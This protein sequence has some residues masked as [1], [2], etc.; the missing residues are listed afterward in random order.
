MARRKVNAAPSDAHSDDL[1]ELIAEFW[2]DPLGFVDF[3]YPWGEP[4]PLQF[5]TGPDD[6]Q[7]EYLIALGEAVRAR[8]AV[9]DL[10]AYLSATAT[11]HGTGKS[12][13]V[14]WIVQ[15]LMSTREDP[16]IVVT[17]N[18]LNQL[19]TKTWRE[20]SKWHRMLINADW[21]QW[22]ATK[23]YLKERPETWAAHAIPW[24]KERSEAFAGTHAK[25]VLMIFDEAS[26]V[27]DSI[28]ETAEGALTTA[29]ALW[30]VF[31]NPTKNTGR[32]RECWRRFRH[33]WDCRQVDSRKARKANQGQLNTWVEDYGED[34]DFVRVR[35][36]GEFPRAASSQ[37]IGGD[38]V[39]Q[40]QNEFKR[41]FG[42]RLQKA[43]A[44][45]PGGLALE[46]LDENTIAPRIMAVD[47]ARK[48]GDQSVIGIRQGKCFVPVAKYRDLDGPQLAYRVA[49]WIIGEQPD[50]VFI[51][52]VGYGASCLDTLRDLG[53]EVEDVNG[54]LKALD[55]RKFW[56]R[57][58][59]MW[60]KMRDWLVSGGAIPFWD[61]EL[62]DD[63]T[64]PEYGYSDRG[65]RVQLE[66]KADMRARGLPS[67]DTA[68]CL[69]M[70]FF[71]PVAP[72]GNRANIAKKLAEFARGQSSYGSDGQTS[73]MSA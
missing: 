29:G 57:R 72:K 56:N 28:W 48:G 73:W 61:T 46:R 64:S 3:C 24:S 45:G 13:L 19:T 65:E 1:V 26:A 66:T 60:W 71:M 68:D 55:E 42:D 67:P 27:D 69:S 12:A 49:E 43:V 2:G 21:F 31:G 39:I 17:A 59:E 36:R 52:G 70:T 20:M 34:S 63:L 54:G 16:A 33:R 10:G 32:F 62:S 58:S 47:V 51:D 8:A 18:T 4:G 15:W 25:D 7:R 14:C 35:V 30:L 11:G 6:W 23:F 37:L 53:Y 44:D 22:T 40:A 5:E 41:R 50:A 9:P 38:L